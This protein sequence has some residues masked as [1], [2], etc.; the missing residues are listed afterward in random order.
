[1]R[2][3]GSAG[4]VTLVTLAL[5][6]V[7]AAVVGSLRSRTR[8]IVPLVLAVATLGLWK[9]DERL[10]PYSP[11]PLKHYGHLLAD[12]RIETTRVWSRWDYLGRLDVVRP[13]AGIENFAPAAF[14]RRVL[15][16]GGDFR[17]LFATG[18]NWSYSIRFADER[19]RDGFAHGAPAASP[20]V[21]HGPG[22]DVLVIGVGGGVD[23][24]L[25]THGQA[26]SVTAV[27]INPMMIAAL[28]GLGPGWWS[29]ALDD[30]RIAF[31]QMDGRTFAETT[32]DR[33]DVITLTA[34]DTGA[35]SARGGLV[36]LENYLY[37][38]EAF[39]K[40]L[41]ILK[42]GGLVFVLRPVPDLRKIA[43]TAAE[44]LKRRGAPQPERHFVM[45][46]NEEWRGLLIFGEPVTAPVVER[47]K[48]AGQ[49]GLGS[50]TFGYLPGE[51]STDPVFG[52]A[53]EALAERRVASFV[54]A[55]PQARPIVDDWPFFYHSEP[56]LAGSGAGRLLARILLWVGGVGFVLIVLPL[57]AIPSV[58]SEARGALSTFPYFGGIGVGFMLAEIAL[59]QKLV[60]FLGHPVYSI[61]VTLFV[62][63]LSTGA[64][65]FLSGRLGER[66]AGAGR[67]ALLVIAALLAASAWVFLRGLPAWAI[68]PSLGARIAIAALALF[69]LGVLLGS[70]FPLGIRRLTAQAPGLVPLAWAVNA[71][72][73]V[74]GSVLAMVIAIGAGFATVLA[75]AAAAYLVA[76]LAAGSPAGPAATAPSR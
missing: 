70:A 32:P 69:P 19:H 44:A 61:T 17:F 66:A 24:F 29:G 37:T 16:L 1:M 59:M 26:R 64:G 40:Y 14:A 51:A 25:A 49:T 72:F 10:Y 48:A 47:L 28:R 39:E 5:G 2:V 56:S 21:A 3:T 18:D 74:L 36:L 67:A 22:A 8:A 6:L 42:P 38:V 45:L 15:D 12:P 71:V 23:L 54:A 62:L 20:Y 50:G 33:Y 75:S 43:I 73:S 68:V 31:R 53:M 57:L 63:L 4:R 9:L 27:E 41:S 30:P 13:G 65:S 60:L 55:N 7:A 58:R 46:G 52:P 34:V 11:S 35:S 76:F